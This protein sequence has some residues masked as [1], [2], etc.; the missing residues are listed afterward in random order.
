MVYPSRMT[1]ISMAILSLGVS[2]HAMADDAVELESINVTGYK[3]KKVGEETVSRQTLDNEMVHD[4]NDLVRHQTGIGVKEGGRFG[5][6]G[7]A[8]RGQDGNRVAINVDG[9]AQANYQDSG[10]LSTYGLTPSSRAPIE[11]EFMRSVD[12]QRGADSWSS[13]SGA[14]GGAVS[15]VTKNPRDLIVDDKDYGLYGKAG[16][17]SKNREWLTTVG[18]AFIKDGWEGLLLYS[19]R[20]GDETKNNG[21]GDDIIGPGRGKPDPEDNKKDS[22]LAKFAYQ[23]NDEHKVGLVSSYQKE[24]KDIDEKSYEGR[25]EVAMR[26]GAKPTLIQDGTRTAKDT[27]ELET[28]GLFYEYTPEDSFLSD[29]KFNYDHQKLENRAKSYT[30]NLM[31]DRPGTP[32]KDKKNGDVRFD[33]RRYKAKIDQ[34]N[35]ESNFE[36]FNLGSTSHRLSAKAGYSKQ[37]I[38]MYG[39]RTDKI[40]RPVPVVKPEDN[41]FTP[42]KQK[43]LFL[44]FEDQ[45][46]ITDVIFGHAGI[47]YDKTKYKVD[48]NVKL[49]GTS[50]NNLTDNPNK[51]RNM[52][53]FTWTTGLGAKLNETW[54]LNSKVSTGF[55]MPSA[56]DMYYR[57]GDTGRGFIY[58][59]NPDLKTEKSTNFEVSLQGQSNIGYLNAGIY[60]SRYRNL[61][62]D[63]PVAQM[64]KGGDLIAKM[65]NIDKA[66]VTGIDVDGALYLDQLGWTQDKWIAT[67]AFSYAKGSS[68]SG[69]G[70][71]ALQPFKAVL[72]LGYEANDSTWGVMSNMTYHGKKSSS[73][74]TV[75]RLDLYDLVDK[76]QYIYDL[77]FPHRPN[78]AFVFDL[79]GYYKP[80]KNVTV[81][82]GIFNVFDKKYATWDDRRD[83]NFY[84]HVNRVDDKTGQGLDRFSAPRRNFA[85]SLEAKF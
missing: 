20:D 50:E 30:T 13:G 67:G 21:R 49:D 48:N 38:K 56:A 81:R 79:T 11:M 29:L 10:I 58:L 47:R 17:S 74:T 35:L 46:K 85:V 9:V 42:V 41:F 24:K 4:V 66:H 77:D 6:R 75:Q 32:D 61:I 27:S 14:I 1:I 83:I 23:I 76:Q 68:D 5:N 65:E 64:K 18:G 71:M 26:P 54:V 62:S 22:V 44:S 36:T 52:S 63:M 53:H 84:G 34:F 45:F 60:H 33:D 25:M 69:R 72:G 57:F 73:N 82:A 2:A 80:T 51:N 31:A 40:N 28:Y 7:F 37:D 16:Y 19:H 55:R 39:E 8:I 59:P 3:I 70:L 78:S 43:S 15:L 12:I